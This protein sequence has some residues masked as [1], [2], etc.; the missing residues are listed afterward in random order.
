ML[1]SADSQKYVT[2]IPHIKEFD[3]WT[4]RLS[5]QELDNIRNKLD[6]MIDSDEIH[7]A[8][9]MPGADWTDTEFEPIYSKACQHNER[10]AGMC[11][12]I[13]VWETMMNRD[14]T[15]GFGKY[16]KDN[17]PI[18]SMTYFRFGVPPPRN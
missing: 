14:D 18:E 10:L 3:F 4:S 16:E 6:S 1:Y 9:W 17:T 2:I 8:G 11:F 5:R 12:G 15:W 13:F 7:T